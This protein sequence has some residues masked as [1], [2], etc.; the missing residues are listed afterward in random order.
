MSF[1]NI[2]LYISIAVDTC[3]DHQL[4]KKNIFKLFFLVTI[5]QTAAHIWKA[6]CACAILSSLEKKIVSLQKKIREFTK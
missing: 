6:K 3:N 1:K 2:L 4:K 5:A